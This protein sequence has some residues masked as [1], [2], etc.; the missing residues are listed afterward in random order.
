M[1]FIFIS[2]VIVVDQISKFIIRSNFAPGETLPVIEDIFHITYV[3]NRGAAFSIFQNNTFFLVIVPIVAILIGSFLMIK[4]Y[5]KKRRKE[6]ILAW[7]IASI[8]AGGIGNMIDRMFFGFVT[9]MFDFRI[10]PVFNVADVFVT[11]GCIAII[12]VILFFD[13]ESDQKGRGNRI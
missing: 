13:N 4:F 11:I 10:F 12:A 2:T 3:Q 1:I 9:D 5:Q 8:I 6:K 7:I